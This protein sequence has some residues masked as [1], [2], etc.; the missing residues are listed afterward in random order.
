[1]HTKPNILAAN[2]EVAAASAGHHL[3]KTSS[4]SKTSLLDS[5]LVDYLATAA[6]REMLLATHYLLAL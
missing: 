3:L 5:V 2:R 6:T 1:M 4:P